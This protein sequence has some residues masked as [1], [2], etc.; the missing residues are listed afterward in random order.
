MLP[1]TSG[2][3][4]LPFA[5]PGVVLES[6]AAKP[7]RCGRRLLH[8]LARDGLPAVDATPVKDAPLPAPGARSPGMPWSNRFA[9]FGLAFG[10]MGN[11]A[12]KNNKGTYLCHVT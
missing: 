3:Q 8:V 1:L 12:A 6:W 5:L 11:K 9:C 10:V 2:Q 7:V 4:D